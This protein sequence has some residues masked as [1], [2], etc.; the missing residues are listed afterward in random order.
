MQPCSRAGRN[1]A[2]GAKVGFGGPGFKASV[3]NSCQGQSKN[4]VGI[5]MLKQFQIQGII[6]DNGMVVVRPFGPRPWSVLEIY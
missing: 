3:L 2:Y 4:A 6:G 5:F 1:R